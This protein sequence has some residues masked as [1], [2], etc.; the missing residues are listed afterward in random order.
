[1]MDLQSSLANHLLSALDQS[2]FKRLESH[3]EWVGM[4][5][6]QVLYEPGSKIQYAYF[7]TSALISIGYIFEDG[8]SA[9]MACVGNEGLLGISICMGSD[10]SPS[11]ALV[12]NAGYGYRIKA[13]I[14]KEEFNRGG[15]LFHVLL[16][17]MQALITQMS[18][19]AVCN[20][21]HCIDQQLSRF[22]LLG[23]D[24]VPNNRLDMTQDVIA[25][26]LGVRR[27]GVTAA[28][29]KLQKSGLIS[30]SRG[31]ITV[32]DRK[33][34]EKVTC[35]CYKVVKEEFDRLLPSL[36]NGAKQ[37]INTLSLH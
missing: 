31:Q 9:E 21:H 25:S 4:P 35:E 12:H 24:R 16:R 20:R 26:S 2:D 37:R 3:L 18:Q 7:P 33:G 22:L 11:T 30:Y 29:G 17:Y 6:G 15:T 28:A 14:L 34:L 32:L 10:S 13:N 1:M 8:A 19:T 5:A 23:I 36:K 27:E